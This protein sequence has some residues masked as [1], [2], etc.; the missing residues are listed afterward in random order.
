MS[1][2]RLNLLA[3]VCLMAGGCASLPPHFSHPGTIEQQR[4][5]ATIHDPYGDP[6]LA[7]YLDGLRPRDY[8]EPLAEPV[9]NRLYVD[10]PWG[11]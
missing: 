11:R 5:R 9:R 8:L 6:D 2:P 10:S 3:A 7:P 1:R 4:R